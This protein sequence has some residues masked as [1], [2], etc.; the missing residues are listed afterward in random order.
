[1]GK[2]SGASRSKRRVKTV[3]KEKAAACQNHT[4]VKRNPTPSARSPRDDRAIAASATDHARRYGTPP[5]KTL[6]S[7][8]RGSKI[9]RGS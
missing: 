9:S 5:S 4:L 8:R 3:P 1:M 7:A 2:G 6:R